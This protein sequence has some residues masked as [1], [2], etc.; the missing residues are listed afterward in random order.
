M[1]KNYYKHNCIILPPFHYKI[2]LTVKHP[3][4]PITAVITL[5]S[6]R[7]ETHFPSADTEPLQAFQMK[8][9]SPKE[10][11]VPISDAQS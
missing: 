4:F 1:K 2:K 7:L 5:L 9:K 11:W 3:I 10:V 8:T 6:K